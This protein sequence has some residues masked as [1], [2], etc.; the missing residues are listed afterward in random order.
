MISR[1]TVV[2]LSVV[3]GACAGSQAGRTSN[4]LFATPEADLAREHAPDLYGQ[5]ESAW[6]QASDAQRR[7]DEQAADDY[8]TES[9]LW[10]A[11]AIAEAARVQLDRRRAELQREEE[12]WGKQLARDQEASAIVARDISRHEAN[13][14]A[15]REAERLATLTEATTV[16]DATL[17]A[18]LTR[19]RLNLALA[20]A[21]GATDEHLLPL[22]E[23]ADFVKR[24]RPDAARVAESLLLESEI[25]IG[26]TRADWPEPRPG[27]S[28]ALVQT[29]SV[30]GFSA[31]R[32]GSAVL[33]RSERFFTSKGQVSS[34]TVRRF[35]GLLE[36]FPHGPVA[37]QVAVPELSSRVWARRVAQL[38]ERFGRMDDP[39][40]I[41]TSMVATE[42]LSEG[43]VQCTF[44]AYREP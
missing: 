29:A 23:R 44:A 43:T 18:V 8:R 28:T 3:I 9:R 16:S 40:R 30:T 42:S 10:L 36:A 41:S 13:A 35:A 39:G 21:L 33:I 22:R 31:D 14:V 12:H 26:Q 38:V 1:P 11:A 2:L 27:A 15:L 25:L 5:A 37:C 24:K 17:D 7:K 19:V 32:L 20:E 34:A 4:V 6:A